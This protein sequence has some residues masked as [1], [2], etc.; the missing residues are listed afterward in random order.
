MRRQ[1]SRGSIK[2]KSH[3]R[4][5]A[6][7][8]AGISLAAASLVAVGP[9]VAPASAK[10]KPINILAINDTSGYTKVYGIQENLGLEAGAAYVDAHGGIL[11]HKVVVTTV[12]DN[13][14]P[15]TAASV[16]R[17]ELSANPGKYTMVWAGSESITTAAIAPILKSYHVLSFASTDG[18]NECAQVSACPRL[19][20]MFGNN[21]LP[22]VA[23]ASYFVAH[24]IKKVGL[25]AEGTNYTEAELAYIQ[26][27]LKKAGI[28]TVTQTFPP[29]AVSVTPEM[30]SLQSSGVQS[31]MALVFGT[32]AG[33]VLGA[34][35]TLGWS[36]PLVF[37]SAG[38]T[39]DLPTLA[40]TSQLKGVSETATYCQNGASNVPAWGK[41]VKYAPSH[42]IGEIP[43]EVS[44]PGWD[45]ILFLKDAANKA[46]SISQ[47]AL[48]NA[49]QTI[50]EKKGQPGFNFVTFQGYCFS[51]TNHQNVCNTAS[52]FQVV[53]VGKLVNSR[54]H[55]LG[56]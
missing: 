22:E 9:S 48:M 30:Q 54:L 35:S 27:D 19:F 18:S 43:C 34:R 13:G 15:A 37:D 47:S 8:L 32:S 41:E 49:V 5:Q 42:P 26:K 16:A 11:G 29:T 55:P 28:T 52:D 20:I 56:S 50:K 7:M 3:V 36:A 38:S 31:V 10:S 24:K 17:Q 4:W 25:L 12:N 53:P 46:K 21:G 14:D 33:Y 39:A 40:P 44:G 2:R 51:H 45:S 6:M 1:H 23:D